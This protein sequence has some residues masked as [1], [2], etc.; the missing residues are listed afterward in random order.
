MRGFSTDRNPLPGANDTPAYPA[1][2]LTEKAQ[3]LRQQAEMPCLTRHPH[4]EY[5][6]FGFT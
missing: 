6:E 2:S 1:S 3:F 4:P 5:S